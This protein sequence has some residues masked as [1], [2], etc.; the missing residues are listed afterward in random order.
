MA[1]TGELWSQEISGIPTQTHPF[2]CLVISLGLSLH[3]PTFPFEWKLFLPTKKKTAATSLGA[4]GGKSRECVVFV[5]SQSIPVI[6]LKTTTTPLQSL[7]QFLTWMIIYHTWEWSCYFLKKE[8]FTNKA[9]KD[10]GKTPQ[11]WKEVNKSRSC[12]DWNWNSKELYKLN[13]LFSL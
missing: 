3:L 6:P 11:T 7:L 10:N 1:Q 2:L 9:L 12:L 5:A 8:I 13:I 4:R